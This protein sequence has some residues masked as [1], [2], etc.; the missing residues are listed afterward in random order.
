MIMLIKVKEL[1]TISLKNQK[2][3]IIIKI[4]LIDKK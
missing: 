1:Y 3:I 4:I 2:F